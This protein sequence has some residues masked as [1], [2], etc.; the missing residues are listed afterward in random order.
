MNK[1]C[2]SFVLCETAVHAYYL[3]DTCE[4]L[5]RNGYSKFSEMNF[6]E[7]ITYVGIG[8]SRFVGKHRFSIAFAL[9]MLITFK[10]YPLSTVLQLF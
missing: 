4:L 9:V 5:Y 2:R 8:K 7:T 3:S 1:E 6:G 10:F